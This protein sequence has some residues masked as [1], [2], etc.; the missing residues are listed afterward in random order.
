MAKTGAVL[1]RAGKM[2][3]LS[4]SVVEALQKNLT[5]SNTGNLLFQHAFIRNIYQP[6]LKKA[7]LNLQMDGNSQ[8]PSL[9]RLMDR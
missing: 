1:V 8:K 6:N 4:T 2:P 5:L 9:S 3:F 7:L